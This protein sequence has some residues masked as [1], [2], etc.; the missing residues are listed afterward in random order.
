MVD[1]KEITILIAEDEDALSQV[2][3]NK[4]TRFGY[5][6]I[7]AKNGNEA[8]KLIKEQKPNIVLLD[9]MMP[10]KNGFEVLAEKAT[11]LS[12]KNI[13]VIIF[14]NLN[15]E[16]DKKKVMALGAL[17]F[18]VKADLSINDVLLKVEGALKKIKK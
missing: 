15:Q 16:E 2:L 5:T 6:I 9:L 7:V 13:P 8:L 14:S 11:D 4:F 1:N 12:I 10:V 17:D 18:Y 3:S